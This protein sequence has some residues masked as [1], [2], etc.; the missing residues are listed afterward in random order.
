MLAKAND[1]AAETNQRHSGSLTRHEVGQDGDEK[2]DFRD[3]PHNGAELDV[4]I[5]DAAGE[6]VVEDDELRHDEVGSSL[7]SGS[8]K[9]GPSEQAMKVSDGTRQRYNG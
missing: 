1:P 5:V 7:S 2:Q 3:D 6:V 8:H 4:A 9:G